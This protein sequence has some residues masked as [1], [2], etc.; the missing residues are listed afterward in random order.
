[1]KIGQVCHSFY[2][3]FGGIETHVQAISEELAERSHDVTVVTTDPS[4]RLPKEHFF[5]GVKIVRHRSFAPG[6]AYYFSPTLIPYI[7]ESKFDVIHVHGYHSLIPLQATI[8]RRGNGCLVFTT[9]FKGSSHSSFRRGLLPFYRQLMSLVMKS[10]DAIICVSENERKNLEFMFPRVKSKF[11]V[12]PNGVYVEEFETASKQQR[13]PRVILTVSRL[14]KYKGIQYLIK[15]LESLPSEFSLRIVGKGSYGE[16]LKKL[17]SKLHVEDRVIFKENLS[18]E[19]L[20]W[21]Y[22]N[23]GVFALLSM[24]EAFGVSVAEALAS[25]LPCI[26]ADSGALSEWIRH[27]NC[28]G[29]TYPINV[30]E[31]AQKIQ[32]MIGKPCSRSSIPS[33]KETVDDLEGIYESASKNKKGF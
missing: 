25:G 22:A 1:M 33:W 30:P 27:N 32:R 23:A 18:R 7:L 3:N 6:G 29:I 26:V 24:Y 2:P 16:E 14:E 21:E 31:L 4:G 8:S 12:I 10:A 9:H 28:E 5:K 20:L 15:C 19:E 13:N 17:T 11:H